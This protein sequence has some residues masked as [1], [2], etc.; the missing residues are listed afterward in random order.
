MPPASSGLEPIRARKPFG[1]HRAYADIV[2]CHAA[3]LW[4]ETRSGGSARLPRFAAVSGRM[5]SRY[6]EAA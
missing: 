5:V 3:A 6:G 1:R 4:G 2:G